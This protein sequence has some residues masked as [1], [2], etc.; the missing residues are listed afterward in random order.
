MS[1]TGEPR[2][3]NVLVIEQLWMAFSTGFEFE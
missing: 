1:L 2:E 3:N